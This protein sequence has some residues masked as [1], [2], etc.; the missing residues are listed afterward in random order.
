MGQDLKLKEKVRKYGEINM[1]R[2]LLNLTSLLFPATMRAKSIPPITTLSIA[3]Y[4]RFAD[5][6]IFK[7]RAKLV[8]FLGPNTLLSM[9]KRRRYDFS[10]YLQV[11]CLAR[12]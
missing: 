5:A 1:K 2:I 7:L 10:F 4:K 3:S 9:V 8:L 12:N 6:A 11:N